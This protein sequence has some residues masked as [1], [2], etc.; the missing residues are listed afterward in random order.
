MVHGIGFSI[1]ADCLLCSIFLWLSPLF[2]QMNKNMSLCCAHK[3]VLR[4]LKGFIVTYK[5]KIFTY[6]IAH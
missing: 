1:Y 5:P 6:M 4:S 3:I 2:L